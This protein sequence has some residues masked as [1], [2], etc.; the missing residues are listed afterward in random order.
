MKLPK[1][2]VPKIPRE[3]TVAGFVGAGLMALLFA[4]FTALMLVV[5]PYI[6]IAALIGGVVYWLN[7]PTEGED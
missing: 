6:V 2:S 1:F 3:Q 4:G 7:L 5:L